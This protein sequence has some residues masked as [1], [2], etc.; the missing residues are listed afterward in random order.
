MFL[1]FPQAVRWFGLV[2]VCAALGA[3]NQASAALVNVAQGGSATQ[4]SNYSSTVYL[5]PNAVDG[6][7]NNFTHTSGS[8]GDANPWWQ[9]NMGADYRLNQVVLYN[10]SDCCQHRLRDITV[11]LLANDGSTVVYSSPLLNPENGAPGA[12]NNPATLTVDLNALTGGAVTAQYVRVRRTG[13]P[14]GSGAATT[15]PTSTSSHDLYTL[16]L[17]EVQAMTRRAITGGTAPG[18]FVETGA[19]SNLLY[20]LDAAKDVALSGSSVTQWDDQSPAARIFSQSDAAKQPTFQ[21]AALGGN[22]L[23]AVR[24]DGN[25]AD[26]E[27]ADRLVMTTSST[28]QTL[29]LVNSILARTG[30]GG[31]LGAYNGDFGIRESGS[32]WQYSGGNSGD[33]V[34]PSTGQIT[35]NGQAGEAIA[36]STPHILVE[37]RNSAATLSQTS[38]GRYFSD[39]Y[40]PAYGVRAFNGDIGEVIAFNRKLNLAEIRVV[41]NHLSAKY[42]IALAANDIYAGDD[43]INGDYDL[44]VFGAG[45]VDASNL[46]YEAGNAGMGVL[47]NDATLGDGEFLLAGH[48][49]P[50]NSWVT[51]DLPGFVDQRWDRVWYVDKTG[52]LDATL[53]FG[54]ADAGLPVVPP[55]AEHDFVLLYSPTN[56]FDFTILDWNADVYMERISFNLAEGDL[57]S[58]YY[59]LATARVPEPATLALFAL[60]ALLLAPLARRRLAADVQNG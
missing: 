32:G 16:A 50:T 46:L 40:P 41:E 52:G 49:M 2:C 34:T 7:L 19:G 1:R 33:F 17:G 4:S 14:D 38:L 23:P 59:T 30:L 31:I 8:A 24:F 5:A 56:A 10:R 48:K 11:D 26:R 3:A 45:R 13:D 42:D 12:P 57:L 39:G 43:S 47:L 22:N 44:D 53:S 36:T 27:L 35:I 54:L 28:P 58:G 20:H 15:P 55:A 21:A 9:V 6:I 18:G 25:T 37:A 60:G 51:T 29:I